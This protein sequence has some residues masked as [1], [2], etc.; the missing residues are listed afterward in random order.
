MDRLR[1]RVAQA[2]GLTERSDVILLL[3]AALLGTLS[4]TELLD[5]P[6]STLAIIAVLLASLVSLLSP[7]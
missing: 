2:E 3:Y 7:D 5:A 4:G 1:P 6:T